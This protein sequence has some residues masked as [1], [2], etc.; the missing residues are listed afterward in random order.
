MHQ[1]VGSQ[2]AAA[3]VGSLADQVLP[4]RA[5]GQAKGRVARPL[6][7]RAGPDAAMPLFRGARSH[8]PPVAAPP[9]RARRRPRAEKRR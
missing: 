9:P 7:R 3:A 6:T 2:A 4:Q 8:G 5:A 1:R